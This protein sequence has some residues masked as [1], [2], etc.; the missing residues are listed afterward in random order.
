MTKNE[1]DGFQ[2]ILRAKVAAL[3]HLTRH[4]A[5]IAVERSAGQLEDIGGIGK[6]THGL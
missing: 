1:L 6:R 2:A 4:R 5:K 3:K